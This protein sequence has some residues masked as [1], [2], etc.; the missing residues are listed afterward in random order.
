[1]RRLRHF[2]CLLTGLG[3]LTAAQAQAGLLDKLT[4]GFT[5]P[6]AQKKGCDKGVAEQCTSLGYSYRAGREVG[7]DLDQAAQ[8]FQR[9]CQ[10][11]HSTACHELYSMGFDFLHGKHDMRKDADKAMRLFRQG[12]E[13][14]AR[15]Y[16]GSA[17]RELAKEQL[18]NGSSDMAVTMRLLDR[19]CGGGS[20]RGCYALGQELLS[21]KRVEQNID[22]AIVV[23]GRACKGKN[24]IRDAC[25]RLGS[26]FNQG[27]LTSRDI[28]KAEH[29]LHEACSF[30][31][32]LAPS[33]Y[34]LALLYDNE[35]AGKKPNK[36]IA[37]LY[38]I[39]C[40]RADKDRVGDACIAA[41]KMHE[42]GRGVE[43]DDNWV[44]ELYN[45]G[46]RIKHKQSCRL[47]CDRNCKLG[48][49]FACKALK[50]NK[51]PLGVTNC[52]QL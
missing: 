35:L 5:G 34:E 23:L 28:A 40:H 26:L 20:L 7:K 9:G 52:Y 8:Y 24:K 42:T 19:A 51:I 13:G 25:A 47:S 41:A 15:T 39:A 21:G 1:M 44:N 22:K 17:C 27:A 43:K 49:P 33:C 16:S 48:Q 38:H 45:M 18:K 50:A 3:F 4:Q 37:E 29:Y 10:G 6:A 31:G 2:A 12:C 11:G 46:C 36:K 32:W 30:P 14:G